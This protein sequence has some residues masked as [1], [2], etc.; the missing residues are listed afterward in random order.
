MAGIEKRIVR[1]RENLAGDTF[2]EEPL[3]RTRK[4][5]ST[6]SSRKKGVPAKKNRGLLFRRPS[7]KAYPA[8]SVAWK[9]HNLKRKSAR[10]KDLAFF[11]ELIRLRRFEPA[12]EEE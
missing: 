7:E 3:A 4:I 11:E 12:P 6:Y 2:H 8:R 9:F 5:G 10:F 1:K